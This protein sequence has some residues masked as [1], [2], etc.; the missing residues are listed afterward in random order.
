[1]EDELKKRHKVVRITAESKVFISAV[2]PDT[3]NKRIKNDPTSKIK[4]DI[5][6]PIK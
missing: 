2:T 6:D 4:R 5:P 3:I 1:M